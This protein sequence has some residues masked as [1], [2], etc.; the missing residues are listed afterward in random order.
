MK[1]NTFLITAWNEEI[2]SSPG[3]HYQS[4]F[5]YMLKALLVLFNFNALGK[6]QITT[7]ASE[8]SRE[9]GKTGKLSLYMVTD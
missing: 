9:M 6:P 1:L 7:K 8:K 5:Y 3:K 2:S 4:N